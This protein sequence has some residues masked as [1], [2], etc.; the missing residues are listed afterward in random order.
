MKK[1]EVGMR[2]R[3]KS[4]YNNDYYFGIVDHILFTISTYTCF[5]GENDVV[6]RSN[7]VEWLDE[8]RDQ[9]LKELGI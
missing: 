3:Y 1:V 6:Y 5:Y 4:K 2:F 7:E 8:L 9:K